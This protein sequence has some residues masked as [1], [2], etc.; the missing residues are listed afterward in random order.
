LVPAILSSIYEGLATT[1]ASDIER[2]SKS[3]SDKNKNVL[4]N[5]LTNS[6]ENIS[7]EDIKNIELSEQEQ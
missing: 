5:I 7:P 4:T 2:H 1:K 6:L 3:F